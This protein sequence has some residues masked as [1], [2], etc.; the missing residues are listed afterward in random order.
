MNDNQKI[1]SL[2][3]RGKR[4]YVLLHGVVMWGIFTATLVLMIRVAMG[5]ELTA[6][7]IAIN[8]IVF[9][10]GGIFYGLAMWEWLKKR[11]KRMEA[12]RN[13]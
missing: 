1:E 9:P 10:I 12:E 6:A 4:R 5:E 2:F 8:Y 3:R 11:Y 7:S 13:S